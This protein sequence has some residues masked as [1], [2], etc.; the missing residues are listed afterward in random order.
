MFLIRFIRMLLSLPFL[1]SGQLTGMLQTPISIPLLK[2]AWRISADGKTGF[3]ALAA[4]SKHGGPDEALACGMGWMETQPRVEIAAFTG[5][6]AANTGLG[7]VARNM[8]AQCQRFAKDKLGLTELLEFLIAARFD[9]SPNSTLDCARRLENRK[10]LSPT[11]SKMIYTELLWNEML[12]GK[13]DEA[14][15][16]AEHMLSVGDEPLASIAM[17]AISNH[18]GNARDAEK[19][20]AQAAKLPPAE[21]HYY[22]FLAACGTGD[23]EAARE[24]FAKLSDLNAALAEIATRTVNAHRGSL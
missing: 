2:A 9:E 3:T 18:N 8:L 15:R 6:M 12:D 21:L 14:E 20:M 22:C 11:V 19:H 24:H 17:S 7:D 5:V 13:L 10:D 4:I 16:R 23:D 1:W